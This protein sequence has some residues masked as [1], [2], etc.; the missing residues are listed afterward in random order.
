VAVVDSQGDWPGMVIVDGA[1]RYAY[2]SEL[3]WGGTYGGT[4]GG[5]VRRVDID[6]GFEISGFPG[7]RALTLAQERAIMTM[8][9]KECSTDAS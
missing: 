1:E 4:R 6:L 5:A 9:T 2:I 3:G 8:P 7:A